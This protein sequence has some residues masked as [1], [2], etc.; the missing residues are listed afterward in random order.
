MYEPEVLKN[1]GIRSAGALY[2]LFYTIKAPLF[3]LLLRVHSLSPV[4]P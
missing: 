1:I 4:F 3:K 2:L